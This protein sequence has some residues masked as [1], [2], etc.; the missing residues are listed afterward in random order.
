MLTLTSV[1]LWHFRVNSCLHIW[2]LHKD[3]SIN[4]LIYV[5]SVTELMP[6]ATKSL[7]L[8]PP[9]HSN[10]FVRSEHMLS[11]KGRKIR[12]QKTSSSHSPAS[13]SLGV[14]RGPGIRQQYLDMFKLPKLKHWN[15]IYHVEHG[16]KTSQHTACESI[17]QK[18]SY[19]TAGLY[20]YT[21]H[22][23]NLSKL[24][25]TKSNGFHFSGGSPTQPPCTFWE[26]H[27]RFW[28]TLL[29]IKWQNINKPKFNDVYIYIQKLEQHHASS[30]YIEKNQSDPV[31]INS[32]RVSSVVVHVWSWPV[33]ACCSPVAGKRIY[34]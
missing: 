23:S 14:Y 30:L 3:L 7:L 28:N 10:F 13:K 27:V 33:D 32:S 34:N 21:Y 20:S 4:N 15:V 29:I 25:V 8:G 24:Q 11:R 18:R 22:L 1:W 19:E 16:K 6:V 17:S 26:G 9:S 2:L 12:E 5:L 31:C